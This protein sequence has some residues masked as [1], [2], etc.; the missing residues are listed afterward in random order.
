[1]WNKR[2]GRGDSHDGRV[3]VVC[4]LVVCV[5]VCVRVCVR[6]RVLCVHVRADWILLLCVRVCACD[7]QKVTCTSYQVYSEMRIHHTTIYFIIQ[8]DCTV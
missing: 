8:H 7:G 2:L 1:M 4:V 3:L 6:V 5:C